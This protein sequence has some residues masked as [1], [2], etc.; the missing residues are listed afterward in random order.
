CPL[1]SNAPDRTDPLPFEVAELLAQSNDRV[2]AG[3]LR[4]K[5]LFAPDPIENLRTGQRPRRR[6]DQ[7]REHAIVTHLQE[8]A[9]TAGAIDR[10]RIPVARHVP[11]RELPPSPLTPPPGRSTAS[12]SQSF[13]TSPTAS[14]RRAG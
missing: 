11:H 10:H 3:A 5:L 13:V 7:H 12:A 1:I 8:L 14:C 2:V 6:L 9:L 4:R